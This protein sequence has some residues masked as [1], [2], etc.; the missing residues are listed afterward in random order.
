ML[1]KGFPTRIL[2]GQS[3]GEQH[4]VLLDDLSVTARNAQPV[5]LGAI[6]AGMACQTLRRSSPTR[7]PVSEARCVDATG[8]SAVAAVRLR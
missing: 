3:A 6:Q 4:G 1:S 8:S 2:H 5:R 7:R